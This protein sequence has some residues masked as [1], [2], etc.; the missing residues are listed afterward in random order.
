MRH[1]F[2]CLPFLP[3]CRYSSSFQRDCGWADSDFRCLL[4]HMCILSIYLMLLRNRQLL[5]SF[6]FTLCIIA[7]AGGQFLGSFCVRCF[8]DI[9]S[10]YEACCQEA[11]STNSNPAHAQG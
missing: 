9:E 2:L 10:I 6:L 5:F 7:S 4:I 8:I 3:G 11:G 1:G